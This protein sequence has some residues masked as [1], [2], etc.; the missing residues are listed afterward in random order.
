MEIS[1]CPICERFIEPSRE[2]FTY[3]IVEGFRCRFATNPA[4]YRSGAR[5]YQVHEGCVEE[6]R[7]RVTQGALAQ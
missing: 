4:D 1:K 3:G 2:Q 6:F 5:I 7:R